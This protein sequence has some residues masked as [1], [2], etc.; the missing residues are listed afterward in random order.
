MNRLHRPS[1]DVNIAQEIADTVRIMN[2]QAPKYSLHPLPGD[3]WEVR[4]TKQVARNILRAKDDAGLTTGQLAT[5]CNEFLGSEDQVKLSTL[6]GLF[7]GKRRS[8]GVS[9]IFMFAAALDKPAFELLLSPDTEQSEVRPGQM[10]STA[11]AIKTAL[12]LAPWFKP[13]HN[14]LHMPTPGRAGALGET[15]WRY[16][17]LIRFWLAQDRAYDALGHAMQAVE[18]GDPDTVVEGAAARLR[19]SMYELKDDEDYVK[20]LEL[21]PT[22]AAEGLEWV[23]KMDPGAVDGRFLRSI[24]AEYVR[25]RADYMRRVALK[26][27]LGSDD[28]EA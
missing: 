21:T 7:A 28:A 14:P 1:R 8:I 11:E 3:S 12:G 27:A 23:H 16:E 4:F 18:R 22:T 10:M 24:H 6:N 17:P 19:S 26:F 20:R 2:S 15:G 5:R 13:E 25:D 9:E